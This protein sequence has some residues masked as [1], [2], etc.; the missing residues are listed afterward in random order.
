MFFFGEPVS[1]PPFSG[2]NE[3]NQSVT[4]LLEEICRILPSKYQGTCDSTFFVLAPLII[5]LIEAKERPDVI[6][7]Q[8]KVFQC[9]GC[10]LYPTEEVAAAPHLHDLN[11]RAWVLSDILLR[12]KKRGIAMRSGVS[13]RASTNPDFPAIDE[14]HDLFA[15]DFLFRGMDQ[16]CD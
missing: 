3:K 2:V 16:D 8:L 6:C 13:Q 10:Q 15:P 5:K 4:S 14:D 7:N 11:I 1:I 9:N 12:H